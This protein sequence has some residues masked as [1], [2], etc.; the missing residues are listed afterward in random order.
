MSKKVKINFQHLDGSLQEVEAAVGQS[1]MNAA[2]Y[3]DVDGIEAECGGSCMCAT[4]H[5]YVSAADIEP[6]SEDELEMLEETAAERTEESRL[7]C[8]IIVSENMAGTIFRIPE[9][10]S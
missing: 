9:S 5:L 8:Q 3:N 10:Q 4:C 1:V 6:P 2:I 7:S